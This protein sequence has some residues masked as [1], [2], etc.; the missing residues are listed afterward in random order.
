MS[1]RS[2]K[3]ETAG[4]SE[5]PQEK[6]GF[7]ADYREAYEPKKQ[8]KKSKK[9][10]LNSAI[11]STVKTVTKMNISIPNADKDSSE[12]EPELDDFLPESEKNTDEAMLSKNEEQLPNITEQEVVVVRRRGKHKYGIA[13]G[14]FVMV[15]ALVGVCFIVGTIGTNIY[16]AATDD[17]KLRLYDSFLS[18]A[19]MQDPQPFDTPAAANE[20]MVLQASLWRAVTVNGSQYTDYDDAGRTKVPLGDVVDACHE[21][22]GPDC[23]LQ[24]ESQKNESFFEYDSTENMFHVMP[25]SSQSSFAAYTV[26]SRKS[27]DATVL[28]VGYVTASDDSRNSISSQPVVPKPVKY[29][30]YV[31]KTNSSTGKEYIYAVHTVTENK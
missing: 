18:A 9:H 13:A 4:S 15:L 3:K 20:G 27:G 28:K 16:K 23:Q 26:S 7:T 8:N 1:E 5:K 22:F 30:E 19:V 12:P 2:E 10:M 25:Y 14:V 21:L 31:M 29:M 24:P 11:Q 17:S 6:S